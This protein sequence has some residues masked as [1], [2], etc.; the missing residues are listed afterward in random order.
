MM[1]HSF[2]SLQSSLPQDSNLFSGWVELIGSF[3]SYGIFSKITVCCCKL[4]L[5]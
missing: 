5:F 1:Q 4:E 2:G 3:W